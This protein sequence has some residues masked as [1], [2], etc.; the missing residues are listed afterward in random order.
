MDG[1]SNF[2]FYRI[3]A[4]SLAA[5]LFSFIPVK[6]TFP[7]S[8]VLAVSAREDGGGTRFHHRGLG[9]SFI[10]PPGMHGRSMGSLP[11]LSWALPGEK[12]FI[13]LELHGVPEGKTFREWMEEQG[14]VGGETVLAGGVPALTRASLFEAVYENSIFFLHRKMRRIVEIQLVVPEISDWMGPQ[15]K[16]EPQYRAQNAIFNRIV[17][18]IRFSGALKK[19]PL[20]SDGPIVE[21]SSDLSSFEVAYRKVRLR[22]LTGDGKAEL[23]SALSVRIGEGRDLRFYSYVD[24]FEKIGGVFRH[25]YRVPVESFGDFRFHDVDGDGA[26]ELIV[27][28][29]FGAHGY[30]LNVVRFKDPWPE[31]LWKEVNPHGI[32]LVKE[33]ER[34]AIIKTGV[35]PPRANWSY[36]DPHPW[37][38]YIWSGER[39]EFERMESDPQ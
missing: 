25:I 17:K 5:V 9:F 22:D 10:L 12:W 32:L 38:R 7:L 19:S 35:P 18:S 16:V 14:G 27:E 1:W 13:I 21:E 3:I 28:G 2:S 11:T 23:V 31:D 6:N 29:I 8:E 34:G 4:F 39:F 37:R 36:A 26:D 24:V 30:F 20:A 33:P 15:E